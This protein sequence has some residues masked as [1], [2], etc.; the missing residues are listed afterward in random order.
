[1]ETTILS[2]VRGTFLYF[3]VFSLIP[4]VVDNDHHLYRPVSQLVQLRVVCF[5]A[6]SAFS[7]STSNGPR[8][9]VPVLAF[10]ASNAY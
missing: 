4:L 5:A 9:G 8:I 3:R 1:V 7:A 2:H 6:C 10:T